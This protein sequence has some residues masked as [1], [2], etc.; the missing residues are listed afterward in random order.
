MTSCIER[1]TPPDEQDGRAVAAVVQADAEEEA[2]GDRVRLALCVR[3]SSAGPEVREVFCG[4]LPKHDSRARCY[5]H[6]G[7]GPIE[8]D[9]WCYGEFGD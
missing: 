5:G 4:S 8:W 3:L 9:N 2:L 7:D 1:Q 6:V